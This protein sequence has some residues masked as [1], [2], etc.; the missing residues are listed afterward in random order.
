M[1]LNWD[2]RHLYWSIVIWGE[3]H[4]VIV[5]IQALGTSAMSFPSPE[6]FL[7]IFFSIVH[8]PKQLFPLFIK[9]L[10]ECIFLKKIFL[11]ALCK[12]VSVLQIGKEDVTRFSFLQI[13]AEDVNQLTGSI[14]HRRWLPWMHLPTLAR[15]N[16]AEETIFW[17]NYV[18][19]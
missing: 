5:G 18:L 15:L 1:N 14:F 13:G 4:L 19:Q 12:F 10:G 8:S 11:G 2:E 6:K 17:Q 16:L 7:W 3:G 9:T